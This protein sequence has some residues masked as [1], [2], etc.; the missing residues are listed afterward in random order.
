MRLLFGDPG[1]DP[2][3]ERLR[4]LRARYRAQPSRRAS[5]RLERRRADQIVELKRQLAAAMSGADAC[6]SCAIGCAPPSGHF[7]GGRCCG[8]DTRQVFTRAE[9]RAIKVAGLP[10][11]NA[12]AE[13]GAKAAGCLFRGPKGCSLPTEQRPARC[14]IY[15]CLELRDELRARPS[16]AQLQGLRKRLQDELAALTGH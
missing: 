10:A 5:S 12:P 4:W 9:V 2:R 16:F 13:G 8:T 6:A 14:L 1:S 15:V 11:P 7:D 3:R